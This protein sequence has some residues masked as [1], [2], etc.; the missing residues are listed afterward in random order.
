LRKKENMQNYDLPMRMKTSRYEPTWIM[1]E[2]ILNG[3]V[4]HGALVGGPDANDNWNDDR[5]NFQVSQW[6]LDPLKR[7]IINVK[8]WII[9][10]NTKFKSLYQIV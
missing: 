8:I 5:G 1:H 6:D 4:L 9:W 3:Q 2:R 10:V 7:T